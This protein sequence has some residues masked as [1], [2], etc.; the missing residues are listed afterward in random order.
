MAA[1]R[2]RVEPE[3]SL[4]K[5]ERE[6]LVET[7]ELFSELVGHLTRW[8]RKTIHRDLKSSNIIVLGEVHHSKEPHP[9]L[10][11]PAPSPV[12]QQATT[13]RSLL[14]FFQTRRQL[15]D[16]EQTLTA[17]QVAELLGV[18]RQTPLNRARENTLLGVLDRGAMRFP[19][20]QFDPNGPDGVIEGLPDVL[21]VLEPQPAF[22]KL[23]WLQR[24]NPTLNDRQPVEALRHGEER[25]VVD[26]ARAAAQLP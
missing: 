7:I 21:D 9:V 5:R 24:P 2:V 18:S 17:P 10:G 25:P 15:L 20:W 6:E 23:L 1:V 14:Q 3:P 19:V 11:R 8:E 22:A 12:E 4:P 26:A 13:I 16:D